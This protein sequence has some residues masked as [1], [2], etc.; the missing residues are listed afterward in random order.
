MSD[1]IRINKANTTDAQ[2]KYPNA[3]NTVALVDED[4]NA[5]LVHP[6]EEAPS[7]FDH[8]DKRVSEGYFVHKVGIQFAANSLKSVGTFYRTALEYQVFTSRYY[9]NPNEDIFQD[10][11]VVIYNSKTSIGGLFSTAMLPPEYRGKN[12]TKAQAKKL[13]ETYA[14]RLTVREMQLLKAS[15]AV[16]VVSN[17]G[18][19]YYCH[20]G[21]ENC[22]GQQYT[23]IAF[24]AISAGAYYVGIHH[25][26][27]GGEVVS[28]ISSAER[29]GEADLVRLSAYNKL[30]LARRTFI[31]MNI[32]EIIGG[33][34]KVGIEINYAIREPQ[35]FNLSA[36]ADGG[37]HI[38]LGGSW[39]IYNGY[40][41]REAAKYAKASK[42]LDKGIDVLWVHARVIPPKILWMTRA[43][44]TV[45]PLIS[46]GMSAKDF[47]EGSTDA[48]L[49][50][51]ISTHKMIS[52][53]MGMTSS[54]FFIGFAFF[55]TP[56]SVPIGSL[57]FAAGLGL[58]AVQTIYDEWENIESYLKEIKRDATSRNTPIYFG[59]VSP[60][61]FAKNPNPMLEFYLSGE[62][63]W[64][65][66]L[67]TI[68]IALVSPKKK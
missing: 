62:P 14:S 50:P 4:G 53:A 25:Q 17:L 42:T 45:G 63:S 47:Y 33:A 18:A 37:L 57:C 20:A 7:S 39:F 21:G 61:T 64:F 10:P 67:H 54:L 55:M 44:G 5:I 60:F 23:T 12:L 31:I 46:F 28:K 43:F 65:N 11:A 16:Q 40:I 52:G 35:K 8:S 6:I 13:R 2:F 22:T 56:A 27:K 1:L 30:N 58:I 32:A 19:I 51:N 66:P 34:A 9:S 68:P 49:A 29:A 15:N 26:G 59:N 48:T 36:L 3:E 38:G 41:A 24:N